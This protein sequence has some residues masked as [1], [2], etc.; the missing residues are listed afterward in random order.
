MYSF[1]ESL[2]LFRSNS[3][4]VIVVVVVDGVGVGV[5]IKGGVKVIC[6]G[7][8][9]D[10]SVNFAG[11]I[12]GALKGN[13]AAITANNIPIIGSDQCTVPDGYYSISTA[14]VQCSIN[15]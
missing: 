6:A 15:I 1:I 11:E 7:E 3:P 4:C 14:T 5:H 10:I 13:G 12:H 9:G 8:D 2:Y